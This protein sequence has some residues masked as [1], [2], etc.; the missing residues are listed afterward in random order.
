M[1][2]EYENE[3][4]DVRYLLNE[5][6][7][8]DED[9][10][11]YK[12]SPFK[13]IIAD[14]RNKLSKN[15]DKMIK[16]CLYYAE[17]MKS[18][19]SAEIKSIKEKLIIFKNELMRKNR[20]RK[21]LDDYNVNTKYKG[22]KDIR[23]LF[24]EEDIYNGINDIKYLFNGTQFNENE[25]KITHKDIKRDAYYAEKIKKNKIKT[26]YKES[27]FKSITQDIKRG[28]YYVEK[29]NNLSTSDIKN[30]KEKLNK[31]KNE[32][33]NNN[34]DK[35][36]KDSNKCKGIKYIR[37]L[38]NEDKNKK[39]NLYKAEKMKNLVVT[40]IKN[41]KDLNEHKGIKDIRRLPNDNTRVL[42]TLD[43]C[44][45]ELHLMKIIM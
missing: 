14:I 15:E 25:D 28:L 39:T 37:Y 18:L 45:M 13:S 33:F 29:M 27:P 2:N 4:E 12:E 31:F 32:L 38:F 40:K 11:T 10:I 16:K 8:V 19:G 43:I 17:E 7:D 30:I 35:I 1:F 24:N 20:I 23:Y 6:E 36:K 44:S 21:D 9:K 42:E 22:I 41:I 34:N 3:F 5:N 26:T